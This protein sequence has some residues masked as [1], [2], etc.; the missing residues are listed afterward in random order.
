MMI[1]EYKPLAIH[2]NILYQS[3]NKFLG[4]CWYNAGNCK[5]QQLINML[6]FSHGG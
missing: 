1:E 6:N 5:I 2:P 3:K 4:P